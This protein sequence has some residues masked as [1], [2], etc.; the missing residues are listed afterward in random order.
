MF[1]RIRDRFPDERKNS[2][3]L[4][5]DFVKEN[6]PSRAEYREEMLYQQAV[7]EYYCKKAF[8]HGYKAGREDSEH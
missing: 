5:D 1:N 2:F 4:A 3:E 7:L 8:I 6:L